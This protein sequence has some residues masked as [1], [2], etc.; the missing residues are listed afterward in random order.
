MHVEFNCARF[1]MFS[2]HFDALPLEKADRRVIVISNPTERMPVEYYR[3]LYAMLDDVDFVNAVA[4]WLAQ[5]D[6]SS[7]NPSEPAPMTDSKKQAVEAC[8]SDVERALIDLR[9]GTKARLMTSADIGQYLEDCGLR[10][11]Q[12]RGLAA[13]YAAAG[14]VRCTRMV[15]LFGKKHRVV[16]LRDGDKLKEA[17]SDHLFAVLKEKWD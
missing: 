4:S 16:A 6:I 10:V 14:L 17:S 13:A 1:L 5:R 2:Q 7:F 3:K 12:G 8:M 11:L 15:T 9:D